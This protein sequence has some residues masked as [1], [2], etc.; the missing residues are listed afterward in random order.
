[1]GK[2][3]C[4]CGGKDKNPDLCLVFMNPTAKNIA[5][6]KDWKGIRCPWL[7]TKQVWKFLADVGLFDKNLNNQIQNMKP[8]DWS[9]E[10][11]EN[12]Y[13]E[14]ARQ[15]VYIKGKLWKGKLYRIL[16]KYLTKKLSI[17]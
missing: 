1:M 10:F 12:V 8:K 13:D 11:C 7:G 16:T 17:I 15:N 4:I 9:L 2:V 6:S 3:I 5:T 14:V